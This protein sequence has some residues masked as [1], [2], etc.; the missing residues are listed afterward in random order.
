MAKILNYLTLIGPEFYLWFVQF[1]LTAASVKRDKNLTD[2]LT[3]MEK[4]SVTRE[5]VK[6]GSTHPSHPEETGTLE[7]FPSVE[8]IRL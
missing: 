7:V 6:R 1:I 2:T 4:E 8:A 5:E 3:R